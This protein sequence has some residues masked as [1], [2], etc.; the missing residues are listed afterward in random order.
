MTRLKP[1]QAYFFL[2]G[3]RGGGAWGG[4]MVVGGRGGKPAASG[5]G[6]LGP[7]YTAGA[8]VGHRKRALAAAAPPGMNPGNGNLYACDPGAGIP[9]PGKGRPGPPSS[10]AVGPGCCWGVPGVFFLVSFLFL[11]DLGSR[12]R[13]NLAQYCLH[14]LQATGMK[15]VD[16]GGFRRRRM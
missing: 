11:S 12:R 7:P 1:L 15:P 14:R 10:G 3:G 2:A 9:G 16:S 6:G 4:S 8:G 5:A 13:R